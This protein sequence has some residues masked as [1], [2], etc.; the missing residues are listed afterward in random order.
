MLVL[1][2][3][4]LHAAL[5]SLALTTTLVGCGEGYKRKQAEGYLV[6]GEWEKAV[7]I[8][9]ELG[10]R[11]KAAELMAGHNDH[12]GA[13]QIFEE[14][15]NWYRAAE[16]YEQ[17]AQSSKA[18]E[19]FEKAGEIVRAGD[20]RAGRGDT[21]EALEL[22][23]QAGAWTKAGSMLER[24][25][26]YA[27][28]ATAYEKG[29]D[30]GGLGRML[31]KSDKPVEA[32]AIYEKGKYYRA[33]AALYEGAEMWEDAARNAV[34]LAE[35]DSGTDAKLQAARMLIKSGDPKRGAELY[36]T[37]LT[38]AKDFGNYTSVMEIGIEAD[39]T[40]ET[41]EWL[42]AQ[43]GKLLDEGKPAVAAEAILALDEVP[44]AQWRKLK[45]AQKREFDKLVGR[46]LAAVESLP[47]I[48]NIEGSNHFISYD[49][50]VQ[51]FEY[52]QIQGAVRN[53]GDVAFSRI[54]IEIAL[55]QKDFDTFVAG[56]DG[57]GSIP[58]ELTAKFEAEEAGY[59]ETIEILDLQPGETR[60]FTRKLGN[61]VPY[62]SF[63]EF[64][65]TAEGG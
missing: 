21:A 47:E 14:D 29:G 33:A 5:L 45:P 16:L 4:P 6:E 59:R 19:L 62:K 64:V 34:A 60:D 56:Q 63:S 46:T 39:K 42:I 31:E 30:F 26:N 23:Q 28:A 61:R 8:Y 35:R 15:E 7:E 49:S 27:E 52:C 53:N 22:Y 10:E 43:A 65:I 37:A 17:G 58:D 24:Q 36:E 44:D 50:G 54:E 12:L 48:T 13:A 40:R 55:F 57:W 3:R 20:L 38:Q 11:E 32:A 2:L 51:T 18:A 41:M 1:V 9:L 25:G